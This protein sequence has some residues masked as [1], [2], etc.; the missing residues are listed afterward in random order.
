[1]NKEKREKLEK[2]LRLNFKKQQEEYKEKAEEYINKL[3]FE[4][5]QKIKGKKLVDVTQD[6]LE[7]I[8]FRRQYTEQFKEFYCFLNFD[9]TKIYFNRNGE[10]FEMRG[11]NLIKE[12]DILTTEELLE[13]SLINW[14]LR[15]NNTETEFKF[16]WNSEP[17]F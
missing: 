1:M 11:F 15:M 10:K 3:D 12:K 14:K 2:K 7:F 8:G 13:N 6:D 17:P 4:R 9:S 16:D 5:L